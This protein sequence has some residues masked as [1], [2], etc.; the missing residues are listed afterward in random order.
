MERCRTSS[1]TANALTIGRRPDND[2]CLPQAVVSGEHAVVVTI[3]NDSFLEDLGSTNGTLVNGK[4][5]T[6]H[7]LPRS[8]RD[9]YRPEILVYLAD[10]DGAESTAARR[11]RATSGCRGWRSKRQGR[12][13]DRPTAAGEKRRADVPIVSGQ[14]VD[15]IQRGRRRRE[16][17]AVP[18]GDAAVVTAIARASGTAHGPPPREAAHNR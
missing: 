4:A 11:A 9:R 8:R 13:T 5:I 14:S 3:L 6:K 1:S 2:L 18:R 10:D 12:D 7:F 15:A 16:S 17:R